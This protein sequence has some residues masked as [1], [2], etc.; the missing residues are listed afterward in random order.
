MHGASVTPRDRHGIEPEVQQRVVEGGGALLV[1]LASRKRLL[2][3]ESDERL[4]AVV[5]IGERQR[6]AWNVGE[7]ALPDG[8]LEDDGDD[9]PAGRE[10]A[11]Q[12]GRTRRRQEIRKD[13]DE[14]S[15]W[16]GAGHSG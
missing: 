15:G 9:V 1:R 5:G 4:R 3:I 2:P 8:V 12:S 7:R 14:C 10:C 13:E 16:H 6:D 11:G